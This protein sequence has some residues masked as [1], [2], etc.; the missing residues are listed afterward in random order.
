MKNFLLTLGIILFSIPMWA[1]KHTPK[2]LQGNW[3][4]VTYNVQGASLD[5]TTGKAILTEK[6][7]SP[8][9]AAMGGKLIADMESY[10]EGLRMSTLEITENNFSQVVVDFMRNGPYTITEKN[11]QQFISASFDDGTKDDIAFKFIDGKLCLFSLK[12]PKQ[13][14]YKKL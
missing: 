3:K 13:Y 7:D 1:Q 8:L 2:D 12:G 9:M 10:A 11:G 6:N 4:L 14:I 5:V